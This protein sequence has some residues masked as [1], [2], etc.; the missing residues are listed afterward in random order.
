[1]KTRVVKIGNSQGIRIPKPVLEE[2]HLSGEVD[3]TVRDDELVIRAVREPRAKWGSAFK[4]MADKGDDKLLDR[5]SRN[6][7][8]DEEWEWK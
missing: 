4:K 5:D 3:L 6:T 8:D 1:M 2:C 7:F